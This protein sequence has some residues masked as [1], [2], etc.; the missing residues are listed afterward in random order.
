MIG[1]NLKQKE[2]QENVKRSIQEGHYISGH[3]M[4]HDSK[5]LYTGDQFVP[6]MKAV[7]SLIHEITGESP[8]LVRPPYGS[9]PGLKSQQIRDQIAEVGIKVQDWTIDSEDWKLKNNPNQIVENIKK[10]RLMTLK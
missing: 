1:N 10:G 7:L 5:K 9:A 3:S 6:E 8:K 2:F 4:T